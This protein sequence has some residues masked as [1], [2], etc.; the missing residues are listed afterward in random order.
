M[1]MLVVGWLV[2]AGWA[3]DPEP[4]VDV[5]VRVVDATSRAPIATAVVRHPAEQDRHRV[6]AVSGEWVGNILY[7][8]DGSELPFTKGLQLDLEV[9]APGYVSQRV[10]YEVRKARNEVEVGL[11]KLALDLREDDAPDVM[12]QFATDRPRE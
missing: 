5:T 3:R 1:A 4:G 8:P 11:D 12:I 2:G 9:S 7:L 10:T 6:N